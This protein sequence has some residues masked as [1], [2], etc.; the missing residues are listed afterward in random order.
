MMKGSGDE[1]PRVALRLLV[2]EIVEGLSRSGTGFRSKSVQE[3]NLP[4]RCCVVLGSPERHSPGT[5]VE[6]RIL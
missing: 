1:S 6:S 5:T 3:S 2:D 4:G